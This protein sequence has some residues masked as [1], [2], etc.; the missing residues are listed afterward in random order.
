MLFYLTTLNLLR[1]LIEDAPKL[2]EDEHDIQVISVMDAWKHS[3]SRPSDLGPIRLADS[4]QVRGAILSILY[5]ILYTRTLIDLFFL[6]AVPVPVGIQIIFV[7]TKI[8]L[9][10]QKNYHQS[11][12][13]HN[14]YTY[15]ESHLLIHVQFLLQN[16]RDCESSA[17]EH[18]SLSRPAL[19]MWNVLSSSFLFGT[20]TD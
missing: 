3:M 1:F 18:L 2:K 14:L 13:H 11:G 16:I 20:Y 15:T 7:I 5:Y 17:G 6:R 12:V 8:I 9:H 4:N 10:I 19:L